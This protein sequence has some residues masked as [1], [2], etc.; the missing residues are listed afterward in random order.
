MKEVLAEIHKEEGLSTNLKWQG[1][2]KCDA[3][4]NL[5]WSFLQMNAFALQKGVSH[6]SRRAGGRES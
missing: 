1:W 3:N 4:L 6:Q 2:R 5:A